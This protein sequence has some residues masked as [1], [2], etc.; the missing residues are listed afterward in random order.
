MVYVDKRKYNYK[1]MVMCHL[2]ADSKLELLEFANKL[3]LNS[4]HIQFENTYK[5]H[6]DIC[7]TKRK[8]AIQLGAIEISN[9]ELYSLLNIKREQYNNDKLL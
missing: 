8:L 3:N 6:F 2:L 1:H 9:K 7:L 5:E 4:K